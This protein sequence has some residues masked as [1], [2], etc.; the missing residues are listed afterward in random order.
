MVQLEKSKSEVKFMVYRQFTNILI[1]TVVAGVV[2]AIYQAFY[3]LTDQFAWHWSY[4]WIVDGG[5]AFLL[6][7]IL[8]VSIALLFRPSDSNIRIIYAPVGM[9]DEDSNLAALADEDI[10]ANSIAMTKPSMWGEN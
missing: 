6:Y 1:L 9:E 4:L 10:N 5:F 7:T 3:M 2:F 8:L